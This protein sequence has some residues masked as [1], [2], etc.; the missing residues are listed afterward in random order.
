VQ[1][2]IETV[3]SGGD[4]FRLR[5][6]SGL[7]VELAAAQTSDTRQGYALLALSLAGSDGAPLFNGDNLDDGIATV[8]ALPARVSQSLSEVVAELNGGGTDDAEK[9]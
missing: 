1:F 7:A 9:K 4:T 8:M 2:R 6:L 3:E 5:E